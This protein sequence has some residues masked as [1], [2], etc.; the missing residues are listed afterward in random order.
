MDI[1]RDVGCTG[2]VLVENLH[3]VDMQAER[4][5]DHG[6]SGFV[7]GST[8]QAVIGHGLSAPV[9][10]NKRGNRHVAFMLQK[11]FNTR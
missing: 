8:A 1:G 5:R 2:V 10:A 3:A 7:I 4:E 11:F 6:M 9:Y